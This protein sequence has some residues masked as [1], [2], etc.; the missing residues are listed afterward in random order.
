MHSILALALTGLFL[1]FLEFFLPSFIM[2][3]GGGILLLT[4]LFFFYMENPSLLSLFAY[5]SSLFLVTFLVI[6][7]ALWKVKASHNEKG[8]DEV[9]E[10]FEALIYPKELIGKTGVAATDLNP[11]G[12]VR[13]DEKSFEAYSHSGLIEQGTS[14]QVLNGKGARLIVKRAIAQEI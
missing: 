10:G 8:K 12:Q 2:A 4:S 5:A 11:L 6:R 9:Q 13:V 7:I 3:I 1:I 14:V